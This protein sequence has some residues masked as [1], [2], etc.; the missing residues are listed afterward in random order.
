MKKKL[1]ILKLICIIFLTAFYTSCNSQKK[2][3]KIENIIKNSAQIGDYVVSVFK[4]SKDNLWFGTLEKGIA[5]YD[6]KK[7]TYLTT[8]DGLPSNRVTN[9]I[10]DKKGVLWFATGVGLSKYDGKKFINYSK[11][12]GLCDN[13]ISN[14]MI[15]SKGVFWIG[16]WNGVC[17][18]DGKIFI[19]FA[20]PKPFIKTTPNKDTENWITE[21]MED[22]KGNIWFGSDGFGASKFNGKSFVYFTK[23]DGLFSNNVQKITEDKNGNI[24]FGTRVAEKD[25]P[26]PSKRF[27]KGGVQKYDGSKFIGFPKIKGLTENDVYQIHRDNTNN[28]WISTIKEGLYKFDGQTF[29]SHK[30]P[31]AVMSVLKDKKGKIWLGCAGGLYSI[32]SGEIINITSNGPWK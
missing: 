29:E 1:S 9:V 26:N 18:F 5:K 24:W 19:D 13:A 31:K 28:L 15:D 12:D 32:K 20:I 3:A 30:V 25:N 7:L 21:I 14:L 11:K 16:S 10:E 8:N 17:K 22:S 6:G 23:Q 2:N 4:D 27:G